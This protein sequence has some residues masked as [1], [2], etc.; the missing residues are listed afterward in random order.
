MCCD[1]QCPRRYRS[2]E[3]RMTSLQLY[4]NVNVSNVGTRSIP[5][6][7]T[8]QFDPT[9]QKSGNISA[10]PVPVFHKKRNFL[11]LCNS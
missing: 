4:D 2:S 6:S 5:G 9:S 7:V 11:S 8:L 1:V 10:E 3:G